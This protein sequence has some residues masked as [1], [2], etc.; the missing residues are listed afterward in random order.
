[1]KFN[2]SPKHLLG[3]MV[4]LTA[5]SLLTLSA[6]AQNNETK[7]KTDKGIEK[8]VV[9]SQFKE[10]N[11]QETP[12]AI[13]AISSEMLEAKGITD[14]YQVAS[15]APNVTMT[16]ATSTGGSATVAFIRGVGQND[17]GIAAEPGVGIYI[18][19]VYHA[20]L[21]GSMFDLLDLERVEVLRGPQGTLSGKNAI[22]GA[23]KLFSVKPT[24]DG[25]GYVE[26]TLGD[27]NRIELR[28]AVDVSLVEDTLFARISASSKKRDGHITRYDYS[29]LNDTTVT[30]PVTGQVIPRANVAPDCKLGTEGGKDLHS[31][32]AALRW[33]V[34]DDV[35]VN[36]AYDVTKDD[37]EAPG[38]VASG[39][40]TANGLSFF[41]SEDYIP[42]DIYS[43]Y[44]TYDNLNGFTTNNEATAETEGYSLV[45]DWALADNLS[46]K[47]ITSY[48]EMSS[49]HAQEDGLPIEWQLIRYATDINNFTQELRLSGVSFDKLD[50]TVGA[51]YFDSDGEMSN[52]IDLP[53]IGLNQGNYDETTTESQSVFAHGI[54]AVT[55]KMN[56][57]AGV[58]Y[59]DESK[60]YDFNRKNPSNGNPIFLDGRHEDYSFDRTDYRIAVDYQWT[61]EMMTYASFSTGF[62]GGGFS[63]RA[64][65]PLQV[66][67]YEPE[68]VDAYE[69]GLKS[70]WLDNTLRVNVSTFYNEYIDKQVVLNKC[71]FK[72]PGVTGLNCALTA[73]L[74]DG[75]ITGL[76]VEVEWYPTED[77]VIDLS[78]STL[79][80]EYTEVDA[81]TGISPDAT[82]TY[83]PET[84]VS[85][86][87]QYYME[88]DS[89]TF[90]PRVDINYTDEYFTDPFN[91]AAM[92]VEAVTIV[93]TRLTYASTE[94]D[95]QV[96][97][98]VNNLFDKEYF[99][100]HLSALG[101]ITG[102]PALPR[103]W[104]V[105][106]K[107]SF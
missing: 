37:S 30:S 105:S 52:R 99:S 82:L 12:L 54:Y 63:T 19:D 23:V 86:G 29:C 46:L 15:S 96:S 66:G 56:I 107:H 24:G 57:A 65:H 3:S 44:S 55:D 27:F 80:F 97:L 2:K 53:F 85:L 89:G 60:T 74:A 14:M 42:S 45:V 59:T 40:D 88:F 31:I 50:W 25:D 32:R 7:E 95:W 92:T 70:T 102:L 100:N 11:L 22:G 26:A 94:S 39:I 13:T 71:D 77:L 67:A 34:S 104:L 106:F 93:N 69:L 43:N 76:E 5:S 91:T 35:E 28:G 21:L 101:N 51:F 1:M 103:Q 20:T 68:T 78:A 4:A 61:E 79:D 9:T 18:D 72:T 84:S 38:T 41:L 58:R 73:N 87:V 90:T 48:R 83:S 64:F 49:S 8:I 62:K 6:Y 98:Q 36:F 47:S 81:R 16:P 17:S 10:Q 75:E 33:V